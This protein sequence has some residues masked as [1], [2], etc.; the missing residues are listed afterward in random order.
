[1]RERKRVFLDSIFDALSLAALA[2]ALLVVIYEF[3]YGAGGGILSKDGLYRTIRI[4]LSTETAGLIFFGSV[5]T[6]IAIQIIRPAQ[7]VGPRRLG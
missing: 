7:R 2:A 3:V 4:L 5:G 6:W 1:M